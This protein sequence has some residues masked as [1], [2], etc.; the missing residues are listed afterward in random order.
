M[1][2]NADVIAAAQA[3]ARA[4]QAKWHVSAGAIILLEDVT[5]ISHDGFSE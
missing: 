4:S 1:Q 2:P 5:T 3:A